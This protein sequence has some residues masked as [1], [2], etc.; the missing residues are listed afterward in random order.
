MGGADISR[1]PAH[2]RSHDG[3]TLVGPEKYTTKTTTDYR[4]DEM[5]KMNGLRGRGTFKL[6]KTVENTTVD[7][8]LSKTVCQDRA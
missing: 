3:L 4:M 6:I 5:N 1:I 7:S 8:I 2:C